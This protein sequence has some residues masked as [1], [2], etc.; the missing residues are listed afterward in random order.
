MLT[1][2]GWTILAH[3]LF[4]DQLEK[5][6]EAVEALKAKKPDEYQKNASTKLL[7]A[8]NKLV[9][10]TI[11]ADPTATVYRQGS[12]L[13]EAHKH[14]FRAKFGNG[15][16]RLFFRYDSTAKVIIFAWVNDEITLRTYGAKTDAY[17]IFKGMLADGNPP[18]D[19]DALHKATSDPAVVDRL[20]KASPPNP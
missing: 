6:T 12:T 2:N 4:L 11:P 18:G 7:A 13:G 9:F 17:K 3:P 1:V 14:W 15:R 8:L 16:F 10:Q 5:L 19:W 20:E